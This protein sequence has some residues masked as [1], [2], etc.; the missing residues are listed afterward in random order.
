MKKRIFVLAFAAVLLLAMAAPSMAEVTIE[1]WQYYYESKVKLIDELIPVFEAQNP[2][3][4]V[5]HIT[6]PMTPSTSR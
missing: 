4:K 5:K 3:I 1:Y 2:G 6:F